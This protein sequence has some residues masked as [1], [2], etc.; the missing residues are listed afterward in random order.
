MVQ[1]PNPKQLVH[2][3]QPQHSDLNPEV[4]PNQAAGYLHPNTHSEPVA[5]L[6]S[7]V[8]F[9]NSSCFTRALVILPLAFRFP[10]ICN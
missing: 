3:Q 5:S 8:V 1:I 9:L 4:E 6:H 10:F 7:S 2:L